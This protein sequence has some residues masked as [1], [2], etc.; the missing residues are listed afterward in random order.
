MAS[1][2]QVAFGQIYDRYS[3]MLMAIGVRMLSSPS[4]A[5]DLL[6][7]VLLEVWRRAETYSPARGSV[8]VWLAMRMRSRALDRIRSKKRAPNVPLEHEQGSRQEQA[9]E[10]Q[11]DAAENFAVRAALDA[12]PE[13]QRA[14]LMLGY[15]Q[16]MSSSEISKSLGIPMGTVKSRVAS[17]MKKMRAVLFEE[18]QT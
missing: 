6:H 8:R 12:L 17:A 2:D 18:A 9:V 3:P 13:D 15:F 10:V 14:V 4:D 5:E 11:P 1:G 7:D 16:G